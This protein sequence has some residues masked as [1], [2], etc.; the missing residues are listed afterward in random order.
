MPAKGTTQVFAAAWIVG[1]LV[2]SCSSAAPAMVQPESAPT[3]IA[4]S[5]PESWDYIAIG[6]DFT[7]ATGWAEI[8]A[9]YLEE[10]L[11]VKINFSN[12]ST[13]SSLTLAGWLEQLRSDDQLRQDLRGADVV[14][15]DVPLE[16]Y[17]SMPFSLYHSGFCGGEDGQKCYHDRVSQLERD[18]NAFLEELVSLANPSV[19]LVRTFS[20]GSL[21]APEPGEEDMWGQTAT[22]EEIRVFAGH[23]SVIDGIIRQASAAHN[24]IVV[25]MGA[26]LEPDFPDSAVADLLREVGYVY[27]QP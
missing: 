25:D 24:I 6:G 12:Q 4:T 16:A 9:G 23:L 2:A 8:Y 17:L 1:S 11:G 20:Y 3:R 21:P 22:E 27:S 19:T 10:D 7:Y 26:K 14:T 13:H 15:F 5:R 18:L